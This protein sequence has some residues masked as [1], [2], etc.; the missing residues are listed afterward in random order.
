MKYALRLTTNGKQVWR[1]WTGDTREMAAWVASALVDLGKD[2]TVPGHMMLE[3][4]RLDKPG[5]DGMSIHSQDL[6]STLTLTIRPT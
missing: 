2:D 6:R 5:A 1:Q 4:L 3:F